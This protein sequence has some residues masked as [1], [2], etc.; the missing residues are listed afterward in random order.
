MAL[1]PAVAAR[2]IEIDGTEVRF[3]HPLVRSA[4]HQAADPAMHQRI[5]AA[6]AAIIRDQLDR[7]LWH[8]AAATIGP[9]EELAA[10]HDRM[11][12]RAVRRGAVAMAIE[13]LEKAARLSGTTTAR[14][15]R[16]L[17]AAELAAD[18][19]QPKLMENLLQQADVDESD[20]LALVRIGWC[21][22]ISQPPAINDPVKVPVLVGLAAQAYAAG[23]K[24]LASNLLWRAAQRCWWSNANQELRN[25]VLAATERLECRR[26]TLA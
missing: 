4:M 2:L 7:Q 24:D 18:L 9:D 21:R 14:N 8:R 15:D 11:A 25:R 6:L 5:H 17:R 1:A 16:L 3:R 13:V 20:Q 23:A 26:R 12:A 19:G 22:E 10:E